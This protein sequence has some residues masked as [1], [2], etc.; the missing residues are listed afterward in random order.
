[1]SESEQAVVEVVDH[2]LAGKRRA[3]KYVSPNFVVKGARR[4]RPRRIEPRVEIV[5]TIGKPNWS[6]RRFITTAKRAG[7][8]FPIKQVQLKDWKGATMK[9]TI[10]AMIALVG[11]IA[12]GN[13]AM[14]GENELSFSGAYVRHENKDSAWSATGEY[15]IAAGALRLGPAFRVTEGEGQ[16]NDRLIVGGIAELNF[17]DHE[18]GPFVGILG[19]YDT[20]AA[21]G[22]D[23]HQISAR[24]GIKHWTNS[25]GFKF[26]LEKV[27]DG[28]EETGDLTAQAGFLL[29]F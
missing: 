13:L 6:E 10:A 4:H 22:F 3:T 9:R 23:E 24:A 20:D 16:V 2:L 27:V 25:A 26:F 28:F 19:L 15:G 14:A 12:L 11:L 8:S 18:G 7:E 5:L 17:G 21:D 1:M 29:R